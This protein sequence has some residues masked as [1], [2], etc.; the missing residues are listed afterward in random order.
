MY[1]HHKTLLVHSVLFDLSTLNNFILLWIQVFWG[2]MLFRWVSG[3]ECFDRSGYLHLQGISASHS[4]SVRGSNCIT[5]Q[6]ECSTTVV[7]I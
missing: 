4:C 7:G 2:F 6:Y 1:L 3:S 5:L